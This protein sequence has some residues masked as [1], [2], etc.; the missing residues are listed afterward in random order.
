MAGLPFIDAHVHLW[1]LDHLRYPWLTPPFADDGP[2]G[3]VEPI[4]RTYLLDD[5]RADAGAWDVRGIVHVDAGAEASAALDE[6][7][8]LQGMADTAGMPNAIVAFADL[9]HPDVDRLL[10]AHAAHANVRGIRHIVNWHADPR[11]TYTPRDVTRDDAWAAGYARLA[12]HG[13]SFDLQAYPG[14]FAGLARLIERHPETPVMINHMGMCV[15]GEEAEWRAGLT[16]LAALPHVAIKL[17]GIGF[18]YR[19]WTLEQARGLV[20]TAIDRFGTDRAM[21]ASDFPTDKLFGSF[22]ATLGAYD[23]I[24]ADF[25]DAERRA[26]F[27]GNANRLYRLGLTL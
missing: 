14:Q 7:R 17:S 3:S 15:P 13:L 1:D 19:S 4:A 12:E 6:T 2:N 24:T 23:T 5:Y 22:A 11:R 25:G 26:L 8:W 10:A 16:A 27:A 9:S 20:L 21:V 18:T